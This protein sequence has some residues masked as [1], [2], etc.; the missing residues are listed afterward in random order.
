MWIRFKIY[1]DG[2]YI[3]LGK[4]S[5]YA[6]GKSDIRDQTVACAPNVRREIYLPG[7][8]ILRAIICNNIGDPDHV[9]LTSNPGCLT[10]IRKYLVTGKNIL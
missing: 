5:S 8:T 7:A 4:Y 1:F 6:N 9:I 2:P 10:C 3:P